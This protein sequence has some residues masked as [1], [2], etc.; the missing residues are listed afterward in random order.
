MARIKNDQL[1]EQEKQEIGKRVQ[2][3]FESFRDQHPE[4][5]QKQLADDLGLTAASLSRIMTG[6]NNI[7]LANLIKIARALNVN[8]EYLAGIPNAPLS[9]DIQK[10]EICKALKISGKAF[11]N[12]ADLN[13]KQTK[14][15]NYML[16]SDQLKQLLTEMN[17]YLNMDLKGGFTFVFSGADPERSVK[18]WSEKEA[19]IVNL[20]RIKETLK[21]MKNNGKK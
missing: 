13:S 8:L 11:D 4:T 10:R 1:T 20:E 21:E 18:E 2:K 15:L 6:D 14:A 3:A 12:L 9:L 19:D 16:Q 17:D 7:T 5:T